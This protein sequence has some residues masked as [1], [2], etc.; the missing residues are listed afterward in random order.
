MV[1]AE[2]R[3]RFA[4]AL[5]VPVPLLTLRADLPPGCGAGIS[6][7]ALV[8]LGRAAGGIEPEVLA[9]ACLAAEG[10]TDPLMY[11]HPDRLLWAPRE[12]R[13]LRDLPPPPQALI[14]GGT[15]GAGEYTDAQDLRFPDVSDLVARWPGACGDLAIL[16][17]LS[18]LSASR[19]T[20]LRGPADD[21][22]PEIAQALG[23]LGWLRAHTGSLRGVIFP[24][25]ADPQP[26][27]AALEHAGFRH[28]L[29]FTTGGPE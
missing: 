11:P 7:A 22:T 10:A 6:T 12:A 23:A 8:A 19:T 18:S 27:R 2:Q 1:E 9:R 15:F 14:V 16:A 26:A 21:P 3:E 20:A 29:H 24:R 28:I 5:G 25:G 13:V 4:R 17:Q